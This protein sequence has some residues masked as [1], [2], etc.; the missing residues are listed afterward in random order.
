[1][2][3]AATELVTAEGIRAAR[4]RIRDSIRL[5]PLLRKQTLEPLVGHPVY[6]KCEHLQRTGS[7]K[8]RGALNL[9]AQLTQEERARGVVA[10]SAGNHAQGVAVAAAEYGVDATIFMPSDASLAKVEATRNYGATV[11]LEGAHLSGALEAARAFCTERG[12]VFVH[13]FD[14]PRIV[15]GQGT[16]GLELIDQLPAMRTVV[17]PIGGGGLAAGVAAALRDHDRDVRIIGVQ[18]AACPSLQA[19]LAAHAPVLV[20]AGPSM[21]DGIAVKQVGELP[22]AMLEGV[23]DDLVLV[24]E[25]EISTA[26]LWSM[27]RAKQVLEG[28]GAAGLAALL[29]GKVQSDGP[30]I[31]V[32]GGGN[33]D[34]A[35]L[36][37]VI[38]HGLTAAGRYHYV[39]TALP[40]R[41]GELSR[42]MALLAEHRV[43]VLSVE[44]HREGVHVNFGETRVDLTL[45]TRNQA[46]VHEVEAALESAGYTILTSGR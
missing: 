22:L 1:M 44:H 46:H 24:T 2:S 37:S 26:I 11:V 18:A 14:D 31:V 34:P 16:L 9:I 4:E 3:D 38:R 25:A 15:E 29:A 8:L 43:N 21:A 45:Q 32:G 30:V 27:E 10:A 17:I 20:D 39:G 42:L 13:P 36:M 12:A 7:F 35:A 28:A 5:T 23:L 41:P 6:L 40:D 33:V 19:A